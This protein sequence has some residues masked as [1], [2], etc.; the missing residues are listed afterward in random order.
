[1]T[2]EIR[3]MQKYMLEVRQQH[4]YISSFRSTPDN[5]IQ[6]FFEN[7]RKKSSIRSKAKKH[8]RRRFWCTPSKDS[9]GNF[10]AFVIKSCIISPLTLGG[11]RKVLFS[12]KKGTGL[13]LSTHSLV[14]SGSSAHSLCWAM[15]LTARSSSACFTSTFFFCLTRHQEQN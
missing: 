14:V 4:R 11:I 9:A 12:E 2:Q 3:N 1:M 5:T 15:I 8:N 7:K 10:P 6:W 13:C